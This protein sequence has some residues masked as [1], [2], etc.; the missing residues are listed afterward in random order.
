MVLR[1]ALVGVCFRGALFPEFF[2]HVLFVL[3]MMMGL[4]CAPLMQWMTE[5]TPTL[6]QE[7]EWWL[8]CSCVSTS[9]LPARSLS[10]SPANS[11]FAALCKPC[12]G[13][14]WHSSG[15]LQATATGA[16]LLAGEGVMG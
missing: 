9:C 2:L 13:M 5:G 11:V 4:L 16:A 15:A 14:R 7:T 12:P 8:R 10:V 1:D 6:H 3:A